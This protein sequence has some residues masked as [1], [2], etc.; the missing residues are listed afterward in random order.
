MISTCMRASMTISTVSIG[1]NVSIVR[2]TRYVVQCFI[3]CGQLS[4][5]DIQFRCEQDQFV[6]AR[7]QFFNAGDQGDSIQ[8]VN[9]EFRFFSIQYN[10]A[11]VSAS[12]P[13][14]SRRSIFSKISSVISECSRRMQSSSRSSQSRSA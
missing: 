6:K 2:N 10:S 8:F 3:Q 14:L 5:C 4:Q 12:R 7:D 13:R 11:A 1:V 9:A